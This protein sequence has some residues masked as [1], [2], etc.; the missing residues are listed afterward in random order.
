M[1][2]SSDYSIYNI[3]NSFP[4]N[5][6]DFVKSLEKIIGKKANIRFM[7]MR[8][9][10]VLKTYSDVT[11]IENDFDYCSVINIEEGLKR[12]Y[13]WYKEYFKQ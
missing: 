1:S 9:G 4:V 3:G 10:D 8:D 5:L 2:S 6:M 7:P 11:L 12:F 13:S